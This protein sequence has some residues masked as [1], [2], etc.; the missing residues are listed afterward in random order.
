VVEN[1]GL[2]S[3]K[4]GVNIPELKLASDILTTKDKEDIVNGGRKWYRFRFENGG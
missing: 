3:S 2:I 1:G 4:K